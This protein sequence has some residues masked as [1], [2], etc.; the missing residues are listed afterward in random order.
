LSRL[1]QEGINDIIAIRTLNCEGRGRHCHW[2]R[3]VAVLVQ[4]LLPRFHVLAPCAC[5]MR[6]RGPLI[7][8]S[9]GNSGGRSYFNALSWHFHKLID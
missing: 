1:T 4:C 7:G 2:D 6:E 9:N 8:W 3:Y 5:H